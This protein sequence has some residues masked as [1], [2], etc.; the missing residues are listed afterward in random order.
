MS[1]FNVL[2]RIREEAPFYSHAWS[3]KERLADALLMSV[4]ASRYKL[5]QECK[6][7]RQRLDTAIRENSLYAKKLESTMRVY[8]ELSLELEKE[9]LQ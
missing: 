5:Y 2:I 6:R 4:Y 8:A 9:R 7:V 1:L 3:R